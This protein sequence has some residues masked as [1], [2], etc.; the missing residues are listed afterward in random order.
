MKC[1]NITLNFHKCDIFQDSLH[2]G[3]KKIKPKIDLIFE[4]RW[5]CLAE[6]L[7]T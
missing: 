5:N 4:M 6:T 2:M 3:F 1:V 7:R